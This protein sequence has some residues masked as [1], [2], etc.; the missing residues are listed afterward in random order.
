MVANAG[1][2]RA[3]LCRKGVALDL[4]QDHRPSNPFERRRI[5]KLGAYVEDGYLNGVL[6]VTRALGDWDM[7]LHG[8]GGGSAAPSPLVPDPEIRHLVLTE[9]DEFLILGCD[10]IWDTM[11]SQRAVNVVRRGLR[12][13]DDPEQCARDLVK[14]CL[15]LGAHDN[16]TV[17]VISLLGPEHRA[18]PSPGS[19]QRKMRFFGLSS[20]ALCSFKGFL[21][22]GGS[23]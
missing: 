22:G 16:L 12:K 11:S 17:V 21:D 9:D 8:S 2:C 14:E 1:D 6:S 4:S 18:V 19:R 15:R 13:H 10:G 23:R 5:E 3:V 7:K 20:E